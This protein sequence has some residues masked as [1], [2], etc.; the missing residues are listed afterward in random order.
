MSADMALELS[1]FPVN[2]QGYRAVRALLYFATILAKQESRETASIQ[3]DHDLLA[4]LQSFSNRINGTFSQ[5]CLN[6]SEALFFCQVHDVD[7]GKA[8]NSNP[9]IEPS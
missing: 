8:S 2:C 5:G 4:S 1:P 6:I 9:L 7:G 3:K